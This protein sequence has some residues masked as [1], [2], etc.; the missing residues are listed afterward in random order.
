[1]I[2]RPTCP[3]LLIFS[4][5]AI[6]SNSSGITRY[7]IEQSKLYLLQ[8]LRISANFGSRSYHGVYLN[9]PPSQNNFL[10]FLFRTFLTLVSIRILLP[11]FSVSLNACAVPQIPSISLFRLQSITCVRQY[12][13]K[14]WSLIH[15]GLVFILSSF[16]S[17]LPPKTCPLKCKLQILQS[18]VS[19]QKSCPL[20]VRNSNSRKVENPPTV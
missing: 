17:S 15:S 2:Y 10:L 9:G 1:M 19:K 5:N 7:C 20:R 4:C 11:T 16:I 18:R 12:S 6:F 13:S 8:L 3:T 14:Y